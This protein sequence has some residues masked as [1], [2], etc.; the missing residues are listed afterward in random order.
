MPLA[1][2]AYLPW[3]TL[4]VNA[5]LHM[6]GGQLL[7]AQLAL[8][9]GRCINL[10]CGFHHAHPN[11][12]GGFCLFNGLAL[13]AHAFPQLKIAV[14]DCDEH[15]GDGTEAFAQRLSN[16]H[17]FSV[18]AVAYAAARCKCPVAALPR[19]ID[20]IWKCSTKR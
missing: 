19:S 6:L 12:G 5:C 9:H 14:L 11:T 1:N 13:V 2:S 3:S 17:T 18:F 8:A 20:C 10:A 7:G 4:L 15:G 16:L